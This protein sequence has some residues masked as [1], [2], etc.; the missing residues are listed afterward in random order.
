MPEE[1]DKE[2]SADAIMQSLELELM[3]KR[4]GWEKDRAKARSRRMLGFAFL[5]LVMMGGLLAFF[6]FYM[7]RSD[8]PRT[9]TPAPAASS[10]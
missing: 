1:I 7:N 6:Y 2:K 9:K 8:M 5:L 10:P 3:Q 4:A